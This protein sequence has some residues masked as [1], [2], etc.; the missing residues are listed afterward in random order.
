MGRTV[1][2]MTKKVDEAIME[3]NSILD[4]GWTKEQLKKG[5][6]IPCAPEWVPVAGTLLSQYRSAGWQV[7][8]NVEITNFGRE[9]AFK[10]LYPQNEGVI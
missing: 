6:Y 7:K 5:K 3:V 9:F 1:R 10:F 8:I 2:E 4:A